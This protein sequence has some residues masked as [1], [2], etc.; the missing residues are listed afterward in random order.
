VGQLNAAQMRRAF[1]PTREIQN[2]IERE[3]GALTPAEVITNGPARSFRLP[4]AVGTVGFI[5]QITN[6][7]CANCNRLRL[8]SDGQLR[9]CLMADGEV[10]LRA[11]LRGG[12]TDKEIA[13]L[14]RLTVLHKPKEH[15]IEDG[16]APVGRNMSQLGG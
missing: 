10:D 3:L 9:P 5:S 2:A 13:D 15:R 4:G 6:D 7:M 14:F 1:V 8:T 16:L 12:S 11:L